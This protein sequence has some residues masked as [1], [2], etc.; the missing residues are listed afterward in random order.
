MM[1]RIGLLLLCIMIALPCIVLAA[2]SP[3]HWIDPELAAYKQMIVPYKKGSSVAGPVTKEEF[4][5]LESSVLDASQLDK[6]IRLAAWVTMIKMAVELPPGR[7]D[8][9]L[10][11]YVYRD[12]AA[13]DSGISREAAIGG[14][15]KLLTISIV[16]GSWDYT[17]A[18]ASKVFADFAQGDERYSALVTLA[19]R[20]GLLDSS[21][22]ELLRPKALLTHAEAV[23]MMGKVM[24]RYEETRPALRVPAGHWAREEADVLVKGHFF[25]RQMQERIAAALVANEPVS[26]SFWHELLAGVLSFSVSRYSP[27]ADYTYGLTPEGP[28]S[29]DRA[30]AGLMKLA[31]PMRDATPAEREAANLA[32]SD[33]GDA[34]DRSKLAIAH[35]MGV[36]EGT[37]GVFEPGRSLTCGEAVAMLGRAAALQAG[38]RPAPAPAEASAAPADAARNIIIMPL[39]P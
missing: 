36:A 20:D 28:V 24:L 39:E 17:Q 37:G 8:E 23:S 25:T 22:K 12:P 1:K 26:I 6:P 34:F 27:E 3:A 5:Q 10:D 33:Y 7:E 31:G 38:Q 19:Y 15:I 35:G 11:M 14:L 4:A 9:L 29:R 21:T 16:N 32:F 30:V 2:E 13:R 18:D